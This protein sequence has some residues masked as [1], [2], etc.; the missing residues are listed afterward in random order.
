MK[1]LDQRDTEIDQLKPITANP[2]LPKTVTVPVINI[3]T[4]E[5]DRNENGKVSVSVNPI[6]PIEKGFFV[7][8]YVK[9]LVAGA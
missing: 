5:N 7:P 1:P 8:N 6:K 2:T 4:K 3:Q 9:F